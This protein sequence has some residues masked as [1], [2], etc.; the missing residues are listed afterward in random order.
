MN[1]P[2]GICY[3]PDSVQ[4]YKQHDYQLVISHPAPLLIFKWQMGPWVA[5]PEG[6][7]ESRLHAHSESALLHSY[8]AQ[9]IPLVAPTRT[10]ADES[11]VC[12]QC[13]FAVNNIRTRYWSHCAG[14]AMPWLCIIDACLLTL[15]RHDR[16]HLTCKN[17]LAGSC[18]GRQLTQLQGYQNWAI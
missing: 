10:W 12:L 17:I 1:S 15:W 2:S 9:E 18:A 8:Q 16:R 3:T 5:S 7:Q 4:I 6:F 13:C 14:G 11:Q